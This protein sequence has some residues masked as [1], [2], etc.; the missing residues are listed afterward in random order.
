M[1][2]EFG[3]NHLSVRG[4]EFQRCIKCDWPSEQRPVSEHERRRHHEQHKRA[5]TKAARDAQKEAQAQRLKNLA[6]AREAKRLKK[7]ANG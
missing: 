5:D 1:P 2:D 3:F 7:E 6:K 4:R